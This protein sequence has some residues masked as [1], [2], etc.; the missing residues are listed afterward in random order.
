MDFIV[1]QMPAR[2]NESSFDGFRQDFVAFQAT[3]VV[4]DF[5]DD[6][7]RVVIGI[8]T[9]RAFGRFAAR[10]SHIKRLN[11]MVHR[12]PDQVGQ[13]VGDFFHHGLVKFSIF[14]TGSQADILAEFTRDVVYDTLEAVECGADLDHA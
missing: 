1:A 7:A 12:I 13:G 10:S 11:A 2:F 4:A 14:A 9:D 5:N 3:A 6:R 8:Q